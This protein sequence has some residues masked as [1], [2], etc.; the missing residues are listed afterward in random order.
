MRVP[1]THCTSLL[2]L[3]FYYKAWSTSIWNLQ[4][5]WNMTR[6]PFSSQKLFGSVRRRNYTDIMP[7]SHRGNCNLYGLKNLVQRRKLKNQNW[8]RLE[9]DF[10][11]VKAPI[12]IEKSTANF[13]VPD[14]FKI[15]LMGLVHAPYLFLCIQKILEDLYLK[16][17]SDSCC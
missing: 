5:I 1:E 7:P 13:D 8:K 9:E 12:D 17:R 11:P 4:Q 10:G 3:K 6:F 15:H 2:R 14:N 16:S